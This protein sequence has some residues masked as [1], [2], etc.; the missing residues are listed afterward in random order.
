M[1][2]EREKKRKAD[3]KRQRRLQRKLEASMP[4]PEASD[5]E[6]GADETDLDEEASASDGTDIASSN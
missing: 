1:Q 4:K 3:E 2:R 5:M 6:E